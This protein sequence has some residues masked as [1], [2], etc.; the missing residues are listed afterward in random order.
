MESLENGFQDAKTEW[1]L[2][3][4]NAKQGCKN[5]DLLTVLLVLLGGSRL[6]A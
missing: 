2:P 3:S 6:G 1:E 4:M 5:L